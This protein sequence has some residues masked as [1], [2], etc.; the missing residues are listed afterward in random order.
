ML[1]LINPTTLLILMIG[2][3]VA[4]ALGIKIAKD[5]SF[6]IVLMAFFLPFER[7]P[8]LDFAGFTF[9]INHFVGALT[10]IFWLLAVVLNRRKIAPNPLA[11]PLLLMFFFFLL[12]GITA[13]NQFRQWTVYISLLIMLVLYL[14]TV[15]TV[16]SERVVRWLVNAIFLAASL[17]AVIGIYQFFADLAGFP[18]EL[19]G[20]DPGYTKVVF[21]FPRVHAFSKEPLYYANYLFIPLGLALALFFSKAE[22]AKQAVRTSGETWL[23][24]MSGRLSGPWLLPVIILLLVNFFL[25]LSRGAYISAVPFA[26]IF[27]LFYARRIITVR[28]IVLGALVLIISVTAVYNILESVSPDALDR[29]LGHAQLEDVLVAKQGES[30]FGRLQAFGQAIEAWETRPLTGIGLGN[31]GPYVE[32]YPVEAPSS[33]WDIVNNEYLETLAETGILGIASLFLILGVILVRSYRAYKYSNSEYLRA[34]LIGLTAAFVAIFTQYN[35]FSTLYIIH[36]WVLF[37]LLIGVQNII[38]VPHRLPADT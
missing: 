7:I 11:I 19:T 38:L 32:Y 18:V 3:T 14:A 35:F 6:G 13:D 34:V 10:F 24:Q 12:S 22:A 29:F 9:K 21:G 20:L 16:T 5:P 15:N 8:S 25:T 2:I 30:G 28:N 26:V 27:L 31:F 17:M 33:G 4:L 1:E 23:Q 37:G 36:I